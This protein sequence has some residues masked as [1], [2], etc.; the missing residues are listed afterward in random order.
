MKITPIVTAVLAGLVVLLARCTTTTMNA[1]AIPAKEMLNLTSSDLACQDL[2]R[3]FYTTGPDDE[4]IFHAMRSCGPKMQNVETMIKFR[5]PELKKVSLPVLAFSTTERAE[6]PSLAAIS[7]A[8]TTMSENV[9]IMAEY[10]EAL[11]AN[12]STMD[13]NARVE[14][15]LC[16][17]DLPNNPCEIG[18]SVLG[19]LVKITDMDHIL[20]FA[21]EAAKARSKLL[22]FAHS[23]TKIFVHAYP[24]DVSP[25]AY[26]L[27]WSKAYRSLHAELVGL[28]KMFDLG[29]VATVSVA[30]E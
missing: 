2:K 18:L 22:E 27:V 23:S 28:S 10:R 17:T 16:N 30:A 12:L 5:R 29:L 20:Q 1:T 11:V 24:N 25:Q 3:Q 7:A 13:Q 4:Q 8:V 6:L 19:P 9:E 14:R 21:D 15:L 26:T